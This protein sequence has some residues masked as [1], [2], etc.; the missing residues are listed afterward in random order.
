VKIRDEARL[1][2]KCVLALRAA[3]L[4]LLKSHQRSSPGGLALSV[5]SVMRC[6]GVVVPPSMVAKRRWRASVERL[7][8]AGLFHKRGRAH[9][10]VGQFRCV[11]ARIVFQRRMINLPAL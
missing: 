2:A 6:C 7:D 11:G 4:N 10:G 8:G 3:E 5:P 1:F 9:L